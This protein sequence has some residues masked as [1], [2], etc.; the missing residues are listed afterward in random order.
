MKRLFV[1]LLVV[2]GWVGVSGLDYG[3]ALSKSLLFF[4]AQRSGKLPANQRVRWR[5]DSGLRDGFLQGVDLVGGYYD[6]GDHVKFGMP[7]AFTVTMM[8]WGAAEYAKELASVNQLGHTLEAIKW[9]TDYFIKAHP[10]PNVF[11]AQVGDGDSD[12]YCWERAEDMSTP[13]AS[14]RIDTEH[15]GSDLAGETAAAMAA[16]SIAFKP[17]NSSYSNL[18]L[19]HAKQLFSFGDHFRGPYDQSIKIAGPYYPC[20]NGYMDELLWAS[21]WLFRA[22]GDVQYLDY[23]VKNAASMGGTGVAVKEFSWN[24]KYAG[25]QVLL[26]KVLLEGKGDAYKSV[27]MRYKAKAEFFMCACLQKNKGYNVQMTPGGLLYVGDWDNMQFVSSSAFLVVVYSDYLRAAN[28]PLNC[29]EAQLHPSNLISFAQSQADYILGKNPRAMSYLVGFGPN[30]PTRVHHRGASIASK[31]VSPAPVRCL[32]GFE[33]WFNREQRDPNILV[34][35]LVGGPDRNDRFIDE[36]SNY[37]QTEPTT[38]NVAPLIGLFAKLHSMLRSSDAKRDCPV[39]FIHSITKTWESMGKTYYRHKVSMVNKSGKPVKALKLKIENLQG[40]IW[41]L[42]LSK[43]G[44]TYELPPWFQ[45][46]KPWAHYDFVYV[47]GGPQ[48]KVSVLSYN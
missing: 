44:G 12:H 18:L 48:A 13:R 22:T 24:N 35:A 33:S 30:Y 16:A 8:A 26:A 25:L 27:L 39:E 31:A 7:M 32:E 5:G 4:E 2:V 36:R 15:P 47:Q 38:Y 45:A 14:Y 29:P 37:E 19:L 11:W 43:L 17:Y 28:A 21:A 42:S 46:L 23:A 20:K 9:G 1:V 41:G 6:S 10:E 40:P 34:G 3:E